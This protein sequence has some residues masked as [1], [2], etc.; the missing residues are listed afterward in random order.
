MGRHDEAIADAEQ[1]IAITGKAS[2]TLGRLG[3]AYAWGGQTKQAEDVL[4]EMHEFAARRYISPYH[5]ALVQSALGQTGPAIDSLRRAVDL[6]DAWMLWL[7]VDPELDP[8]RSLPEVNELLQSINPRFVTLTDHVSMASPIVAPPQRR[9]QTS[10]PPA[11]LVTS[12]YKT[13]AADTSPG[14]DD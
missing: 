9:D 10:S 13:P 5:L 1:C 2:R 7:A 8:L 14:I 3:A 11:G 12:A 6:K 4:R